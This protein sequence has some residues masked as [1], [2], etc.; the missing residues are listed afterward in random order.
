MSGKSV[1]GNGG[2]PYPPQEEQRRLDL[3][4]QRIRAADQAAER[5][6]IKK[7]RATPAADEV[8]LVS[9][10]ERTFVKARL[11]DGYPQFFGGYGGWEDEPRPGRVSATV[12]RGASAPQMK[13]RLILG[14]WPVTSKARNCE[15][16]IHVLDHFARLPID[17]RGRDRPTLL[18]ISGKVPHHRRR[19]FIEN[20]EWGE[21]DLFEGKRV[22][23]FVTVTLR[24]YVPVELLARRDRTAHRTKPHRVRKGETTS[25]IASDVLH[26]KG[27]REVS[28]ARAS[29]EEANGLRR[30]ARLREGQTIKVPVGDW[31]NSAARGRRATRAARR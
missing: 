14:K 23:A 18:R 1:S 19:W 9:N 29:I 4:A 25:S 30:G 31:W 11:D 12:F 20:L 26:A 10:E 2:A 6:Q 21:I 16:A 24:M 22:R 28:R 7:E 8:L 13:L 3:R 17:E 5:W 15:R 27:S